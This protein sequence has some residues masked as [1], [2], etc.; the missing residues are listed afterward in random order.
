MT[1]SA[2]LAEMRAALFD[3]LFAIPDVTVYAHEPDAVDL[4]AVWVDQPQAGRGDPG[5]LVVVGWDV[6]IAVETRTATDTTD[7]LDDLI[8]VV[9]DNVSKVQGARFDRWQRATVDVAGVNTPT[10]LVSWMTDHVLC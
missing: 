2:E 4:P 3:A 5:T 10:A 9:V 7:Q 1:I 6:V 8:G